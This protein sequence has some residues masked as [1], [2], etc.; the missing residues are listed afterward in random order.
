MAFFQNAC[1]ASDHYRRFVQLKRMSFFHLS[2]I[3]F[4]VFKESGYPISVLFRDSLLWFSK[5]KQNILYPIVGEC[6]ACI[7]WILLFR[8]CCRNLM[9]FDNKSDEFMT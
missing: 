8:Y 4:S 1:R 2:D 3:G 7:R 9:A 5:E 6:F